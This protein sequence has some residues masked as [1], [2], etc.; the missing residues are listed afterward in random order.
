M[1]YFVIC[2]MDNKSLSE[3]LI[4]LVSK[5]S[6]VFIHISILAVF[7]SYQQSVNSQVFKVFFLYLKINVFLSIKIDKK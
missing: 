6:K 3:K 4:L 2:L 5:L 1:D 7:K